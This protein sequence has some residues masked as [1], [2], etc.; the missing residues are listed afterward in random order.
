M[1]D[2]C[3]QPAMMISTGEAIGRGRRYLMTTEAM[4]AVSET[5]TIEPVALPALAGIGFRR[6][7]DGV[8]G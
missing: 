7:Q 3:H 1:D 2:I 6:H 5:E 4:M 8:C